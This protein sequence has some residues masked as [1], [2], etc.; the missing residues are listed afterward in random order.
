M[1]LG[2][3]I[4][5]YRLKRKFSQGELGDKTGFSQDAVSSWER[6]KNEPGLKALSKIAH[7]LDISFS[8]LVENADSSDCEIEFIPLHKTST[9][10][11][12]IPQVNPE[13]ESADT[14]MG[15]PMEE[16]V[17]F[18]ELWKKMG[19]VAN[20][21]DSA[22]DPDAL[23]KQIVEYAEAAKHIQEKKLSQGSDAHKAA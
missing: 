21:L 5:H 2:D 18:S 3:R 13:P 14:P 11:S 4:R 8:D 20:I 15:K 23:L 10:P 22:P 16:E 19:E 6:G 17:K 9:L 1:N 12:V 7:A